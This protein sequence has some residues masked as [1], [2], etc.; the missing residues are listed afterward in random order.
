MGLPRWLV[1]KGRKMTDLPDVLPGHWETDEG[2]GMA[3]TYAEIEAYVESQIPPRRTPEELD[4]LI[5]LVRRS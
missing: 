5:E 3:K 2:S 1:Q 4:R